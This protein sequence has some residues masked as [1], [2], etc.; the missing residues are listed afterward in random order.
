M[1]RKASARSRLFL[2]EPVKDTDFVPFGKSAPSQSFTVSEDT[3][4]PYGSDQP[5]YASILELSAR[6]VFDHDFHAGS[7]EYKLLSSKTES[8]KLDLLLFDS[9]SFRWIQLSDHY[10]NKV[11]SSVRGCMQS[12]AFVVY[13]SGQLKL[14]LSSPEAHTANAYQLYIRPVPGN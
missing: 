2:A 9:N 13:A 12:G 7:W 10:P 5:Q 3:C 1:N 6:H 11:R 14:V 4:A 8:V